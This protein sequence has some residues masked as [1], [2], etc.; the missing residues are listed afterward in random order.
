MP[1]PEITK[2][3]CL[4]RVHLHSP[5]AAS[6]ILA[7]QSPELVTTSRLCCQNKTKYW[8]VDRICSRRY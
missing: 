6:Q 5:V 4:E 1:N 2:L 3:P 7:V 8:Y